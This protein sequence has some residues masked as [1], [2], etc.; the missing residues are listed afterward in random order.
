MSHNGLIELR[1]D[2]RIKELFRKQAI[3]HGVADYCVIDKDT[4]ASMSCVTG[5][6]KARGKWVVYDTDERSEAYDKKKY[7]TSW[8]AFSEVASRLGF[9]LVLPAKILDSLAISV[10]ATNT[11]DRRHEI[12]MVAYKVRAHAKRSSVNSEKFGKKR[13]KKNKD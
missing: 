6:F 12:P 1:R 9:E 5:C 2:N 3:S 11:S 4:Y 13:K 7:A 10:R 8:Q